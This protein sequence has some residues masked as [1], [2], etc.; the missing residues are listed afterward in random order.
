MDLPNT[1]KLKDF[2]PVNNIVVIG[3]GGTGAYVIGHLARF[4]DIP[5]CIIDGDKVEDKNLIRQHFISSDIGKNKA[6]VL[7]ERY[8]FAF[9]KVIKFKT[10]YLEHDYELGSVINNSWNS[11]NIIISCV[12]NNATR[13]MI[14]DFICK[15]RSAGCFWIDS[16]NE[17]ISGQVV[18][19]YSPG[20]CY[21]GA[22]ERSIPCSVEIYENLK[23]V[24]KLPS[25]LSCAE[26]SISAPQNMMTNIMAASIIL[27]FVQMIF[28]GELSSH[29]VEFSIK[30]VFST[31]LNTEQNLSCVNPIRKRSFE[32]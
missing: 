13:V 8:G 29:A 21:Y 26:R 12:D 2:P 20:Y 3:C 6:E 19:G 15:S 28:G 32:K 9:G 5:I 14:Y 24:G 22:Y 4:T 11:N 18:C 30:N 31:R 17:E 25:E 7:A 27:N 16:G 23:D 1:Y 10:S